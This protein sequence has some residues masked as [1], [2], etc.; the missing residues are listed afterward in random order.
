MGRVID[1]LQRNEFE[2]I[3]VQIESYVSQNMEPYLDECEQKC[4]N[5]RLTPTHTKNFYDSVWGTI[6]IN[7]GEIF[8]LDSP[9]LQRLR[10]I[11]Q[12]G[13]ADVLYSSATHIRFSQKLLQM[14]LTILIFPNTI[15]TN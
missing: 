2:W 11:K 13:L 10:N 12:L 5:T 15:K 1:L 9:I 4:N 14:A 6:E 3:R 8:I 7:E